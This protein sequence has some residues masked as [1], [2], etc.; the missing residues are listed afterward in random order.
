MLARALGR[1]ELLGLAL[2]AGAFGVMAPPLLAACGRDDPNVSPV[3]AGATTGAED[4]ER[5]LGGDVL[6]HALTSNE[7]AGAGMTRDAFLVT[8]GTDDQAIVLSSEP[9]RPDFTPA[10][11]IHR[12][13][14]SAEPTNLT[15]TGA[16]DAAAKAGE[17]SVEETDIVLNAAA[18]EFPGTPDTKGDVFTVSC[19]VP[20]LA[21]NSV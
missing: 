1:R 2:R 21:P 14:W 19:P 20:V 7:W 16:V 18:E 15:S 3:G 8:G 9:G 10:W 5:V 12:V 11:R 17:V 6:D 13:T 4:E